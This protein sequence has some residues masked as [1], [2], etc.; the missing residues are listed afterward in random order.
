MYSILLKN[1]LNCESTVAESM[2]GFLLQS[3]KG[4]SYLRSRFTFNVKS[5]VTPQE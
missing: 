3:W 1:F 4:Y 2:S 5:A